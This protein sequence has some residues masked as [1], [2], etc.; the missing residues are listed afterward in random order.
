MWL[1]LE[2]AQPTK[3][4]WVLLL[5][6]ILE[7]LWVCQDTETTVGLG[8]LIRQRPIRCPKYAYLVN[9]GRPPLYL[10]RILWS[11]T[12]TKMAVIMCISCVLQMGSHLGGSWQASQAEKC[13]HGGGGLFN[14]RNGG[15]FKSSCHP[16][17]AN[18]PEVLFRIT[19]EAAWSR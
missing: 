6:Q 19:V 18:Y 11:S 8:L 3:V 9:Q 13:H 15:C 12:E 16:F 7:M 4:C 17:H 10:I 14:R 1:E 2:E 5:W